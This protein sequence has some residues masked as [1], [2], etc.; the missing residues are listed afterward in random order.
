MVENAPVNVIAA[1]LDL[2]ILYMNPRSFETLRKLEHLLP[3][4]VDR[5]VGQS[6]DIFHKVPARQRKLLADPRNLPHRANIEFGEETLELLVTAMRDETGAYTGPMVTWEVIT[7]RVRKDRDIARI[8][9]MIE[10]MPINVMCTDLNLTITYANPQSL[11]TLRKIEHLLP[12]KVDKVVGSSIDVFHK[13]PSHQR[14]LLADA[15]NLPHR[16]Q[17]QLGDE[18][19]DLLVSAMMGSKGEYLGPMV[20]WEIITERLATERKVKEAQERERAQA[21]E[22]RS[23]VDSMLQVVSA[24]AAGDLTQKVSVTG[25]DAI[26]QMGEGL[27]R[28]LGEMR[29]SISRIAQTS[30]TLADSSQRLNDVTNS[31]GAAAEETTA[32]AKNVNESSQK[33]AR[34]SQV[35]ASGTEEMTASIKEISASAERAAKVASEAVEVAQSTNSTVAKLGASSAEVGEVVK[36]ITTIAQQTNLLALNAT[37]EAARAGS[38]GKGFAVVATE[39][40]ELAKETAKS[41]EDISRRIQAIQADAKASAAAIARID[42]IIHDIHSIQLTIAGAVQEQ[43]ATTQEMARN[44]AET[45]RG[46]EQIVE[47]IGAVAE[48]AQST[49]KGATDGQ[50]ASSDLASMAKS[51]QELVAR[52]RY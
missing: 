28:L 25:Q 24:A 10:N 47:S 13:N 16:A 21:T 39:V 40:K 33:V 35:V 2:T 37:I 18:T 1:D 12:V 4:A 34:N 7:D 15:K 41:T 11:K 8:T 22:L 6:I 42:K 20:T 31:L 43:S 50:R 23:K 29:G 14:R 19:L 5:I 9:S 49:A 36:V 32:Q 48:A 44:V 38:A 27:Q 46:S 30:T 17:I 52:F 3:V 26:G 45:A 51:L